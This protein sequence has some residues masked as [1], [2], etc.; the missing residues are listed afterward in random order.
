MRIKKFKTK[1]AKDVVKT[2][3][4]PVK[5]TVKKNPIKNL[6]KYAHEAKLP[7]EH[8]KVGKGTKFGKPTIKQPSRKRIKKMQTPSGI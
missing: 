5:T 6:G 1:V 4:S 2:S 8:Y 7:T 3:S